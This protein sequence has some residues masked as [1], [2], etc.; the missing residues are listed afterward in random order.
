M[1]RTRRRLTWAQFEGTEVVGVTGH[2]VNIDL[3]SGYKA[4][5]GDPNGTTIMR[6]HLCL[7]VTS[8]VVAGENFQW[9]LIV[10]GTNQVAN[11]FA[12]GTGPTDVATDPYE[13]WMIVGEEIALPTYGRQAANNRNCFDLRSKRK[14]DDL[15]RTYILSLSAT[16]SAASL[17]VRVFARTLLALP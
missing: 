13:D 8:A 5:T 1:G 9:G 14:I 11:S 6:T 3:L 4:A 10:L 12:T 7:G 2:S 17:N 15:G 16:T